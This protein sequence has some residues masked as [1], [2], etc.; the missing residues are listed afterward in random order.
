VAVRVDGVL[1]A[2]EL[3][4]CFATVE[5]C[6]LSPDGVTIDPRGRR[7]VFR[8]EAIWL[9]L[10]TADPMQAV[11]A[12]SRGSLGGSGEGGS[13]SPP[14]SVTL[15]SNR[16]AHGSFLMLFRIELPVQQFTESGSVTPVGSPAGMSPPVGSPHHVVTIPIGP[17][18]QYVVNHG[19]KFQVYFASNLDVAEDVPTYELSRIRHLAAT[20]TV[21]DSVDV[22]YTPAPN[23][24]SFTD[25]GS[26][27]QRTSAAMYYGAGECLVSDLLDSDDG[28]VRMFMKRN[29][30]DIRGSLTVGVVVLKRGNAERVLPLLR[31][32][33]AVSRNEE[34]PFG[35]RVSRF[36]LLPTLHASQLLVEEDL[37]ESI[38]VF[39]VPAKVGGP[40]VVCSCDVC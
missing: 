18:D 2:T 12:S 6:P 13:A 29:G 39:D 22:M 23:E 30:S 16:L 5:C 21:G 26:H 8:S 40:P 27:L 37:R 14:V 28:E 1:T 19:L 38:Y 34:A 32:V 9:Q 7:T 4:A 3:A 25:D 17:S 10:D 15:R 33:A 31:T 35:G 20:A 11:R 36:Y 24:S